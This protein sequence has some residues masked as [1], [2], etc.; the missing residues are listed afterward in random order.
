M[1]YQDRLTAPARS[2]NNSRL[3]LLYSQRDIIQNNLGTEFLYN[4][5][6]NNYAVAV[7]GILVFFLVLLLHFKYSSIIKPGF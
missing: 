5:F 4:V 6:K 1:F 7:T 3:A 2:Y